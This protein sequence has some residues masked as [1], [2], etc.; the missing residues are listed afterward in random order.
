MQT[1]VNERV[2]FLLD[3]SKMTKSAF[4]QKVGISRLSI[5]NILKGEQNTQARTLREICRAFGVNEN[6]LITGAGEP[7]TNG[8]INLTN[9]PTANDSQ[10]IQALREQIKFLQEDLNVW[11][12]TA[13][14]L[15]AH[16]GK[17][18]G[19]DSPAFVGIFPIDVSGLHVA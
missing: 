17:F 19:P 10:L 9:Q 15:S 5:D 1:T 3:Q 16:L 13:R 8:S 12:E 4:A 2:K 7:Y 6:W 18:N 14:N 11:R